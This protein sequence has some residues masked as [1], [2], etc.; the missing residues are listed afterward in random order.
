M[1]ASLT[2]GAI[3]LRSRRDTTKPHLIVSKYE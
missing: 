1:F 3:L 2:L